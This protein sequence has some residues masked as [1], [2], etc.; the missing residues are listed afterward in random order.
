MLFYEYKV[1][2]GG[3]NTKSVASKYMYNKNEWMNR[4]MNERMNEMK[5]SLNDSPRWKHQKSNEMLKTKKRYIIAMNVWMNE[6][7]GICMS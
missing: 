3:C 4:W 7:N 6:L 1:T 2:V 5:F